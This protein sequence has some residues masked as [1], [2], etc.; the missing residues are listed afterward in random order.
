[1][2][3]RDG[4]EKTAG[5]LRIE[6]QILIFGWDVG[7]KGGAFADEGAIVFQATGKMAFAGGF[8]SAWKI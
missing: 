2:V 8:D 5:G 1:M 3:G 6:E 7:I 4:D